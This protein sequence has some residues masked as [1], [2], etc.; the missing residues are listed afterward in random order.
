MIT[1]RHPENEKAKRNY[2]QFLRDVKG[3]DDSSIDQVA[4]ALER[5]DDYNRR[6]DFGKF[7][8]QQ[9]RGFKAHL[10]A[11]RN[12]RTGEPLSA[13]TVVSTLGMLKAFFIWLSGE[14]GYSRVKQADAEYFNPPDNL[15][16]VATAR[17]HKPC[18]SLKQ[19]RAVLDAMPTTTEIERRDRALIAFTILTGARDRAIVS[20]RLKDIDLEHEL[21]EQD[22]RHARTK[23]AKTFTTW[24]FPVGADIQRIVVEWVTFLRSEK[25]SA[26]KTRSFPRRASTMARTCNFARTVWSARRGRTPTRSA[27]SSRRRLRG[28]ACPI[29]TRIASAIHSSN[30]PM[31]SNST[32]NSSRRGRRILDTTTV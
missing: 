13:S 8:I 7:H 21:L 9:A 2:L 1:K 25:A 19:I 3:R 5:F 17:R 10:M 20:F 12:I 26:R 31:T 15:A 32:P 24:F 30:S 6:R 29:S 14:A 28:R 23:G 18:A 22:A 11:Q 16:R 27:R 4:K